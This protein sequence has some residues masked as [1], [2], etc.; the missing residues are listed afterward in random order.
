M[1]CRSGWDPVIARRN[2]SVPEVMVAGYER[3]YRNGVI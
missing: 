3:I 1:F 2:G